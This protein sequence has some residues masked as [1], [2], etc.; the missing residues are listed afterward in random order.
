MALLEDTMKLGVPGLLIGVGVA[1]A[2]PIL[3]PATAAGLRPLTKSLVK[4][5]LSLADSARGI[6]AEASEQLSDIVAEAKAER[7]GDGEKPA[8]EN[9]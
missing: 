7:T 9:A 3:L 1:L 2:A 4:G 5:Y 6:F 8:G